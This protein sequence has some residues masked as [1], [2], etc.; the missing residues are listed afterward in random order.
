M[1]PED[2]LTD[3]Q[4]G[5]ARVS[6]VKT[7]LAEKRTLAVV[8]GLIGLVAL[9]VIFSN[10]GGDESPSADP[11]PPSTGSTTAI[12][13]V[14]RS[15]EI[16]PI[17]GCTLLSD[18]QV[19]TALDLPET[20]GLIQLSGG[21]GCVWRPPDD[22]VA[23]AGRSLELATG[24]P[25]D[26]QSGVQMND[27]SGEAVND[28]GDQAL[29]F[30][31]S[32]TGTLTAVKETQLAYM[33]MRLTISRS[34]VANQD[35]LALA[36]PLMTSALDLAEFGPPEAVE[37]DLCDLVTDEEAESLL[38]PHREGRAAVRDPLFVTDNF[39]G[40]VDLTEPGDFECSKLISTEIYVKIATSTDGGDNVSLDGVPGVPLTD[41]GDTALWFE[42]VPYSSAFSAPHEIDVVAVTWNDITFQIVLALPD[43]TADEQFGAAKELAKKALGRLPGGPG[44]LIVV[45]QEV[46]DLSGVG[47]VDNLLEREA[48]GD[49]SFEEGLIATL[50]LFV[51]ELDV[52]DVLRS[53]QLLDSSGTGI[54]AM[55]QEFLV[56]AAEGPSKVEVD[57]LLTELLPTIDRQTEPDASTSLMVSLGSYFFAEPVALD[58][59]DEPSG[60]APPPPED[61]PFEYSDGPPPDPGECAASEPTLPGWDASGF[62]VV[63]IGPW[64][65]AVLF[66]VEG[67]ELGWNRGTHLLWALEAFAESMDHYGAPPVCI[68]MLF[69]HHGG[70]YTFVEQRL[71]PEV[72]AVFINRPSQNR[73]Q[74]HFKQQLA[75]DIAHCYLPFLFPN[76]FDV[77]YLSR[78]WWNHA[79]AE[80]MSNVVYDDV[81]LEWRLAPSMQA[82]E[83]SVPLVDRE[84]GNWMFFQQAANDMGEEFAAAIISAL[85]GGNNS[86]LDKLALADLAVMKDFFHRF[87]ELMTDAAIEDTGGLFIPY[88]PPKVAKQISGKGIH[89]E[90]LTGFQATRWEV[91]VPSGMFACITGHKSE[92][93]TVTYRPGTAGAGTQGGWEELPEEEMPFNDDFVVVAT[94]LEDFATFSLVVR[95]VHE[96]EDCE[97]EEEEPPPPP[98]CDCDPSAYFLVWQDIPDILKQLFSPPAVSG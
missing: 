65:G 89:E 94:S 46:P 9:A 49:W 28:V 16:P 39:A 82:Q 21:E 68:H 58:E 85:P 78:R 7:M 77:T 17:D 1:T 27:A 96:E 35:R 93:A 43:L 6:L 62:D 11:S 2:P 42:N 92:D 87:S 54:I 10:L 57:R 70:S 84:A 98:P 74:D 76:Q 40:V 33:F 30:G 32:D 15:H 56:S 69:S 25:S 23:V 55:A 95:D 44:E 53:T 4:S 61:V 59:D 67:L 18:S 52:N 75:A 12:E 71:N 31:G 45:S 90:E 79:I 66:P 50:R 29:W 47:F 3:N 36:I 34:D 8:I 91:S 86:L 64:T 83:T 22:E 20:G 72:C 51:G 5:N 60:Y 37:V 88:T 13:T 73:N 14:T 41:V 38:A 24:D 63:D 48:D 81:N 26:F 19:I 97:D 80:Y